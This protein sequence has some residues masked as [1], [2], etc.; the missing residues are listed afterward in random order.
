MKSAA[1]SFAKTA[2]PKGEG[3]EGGKYREKYIDARDSLY[4]GPSSVVLSSEI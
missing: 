3:R 2:T 4:K 1:V